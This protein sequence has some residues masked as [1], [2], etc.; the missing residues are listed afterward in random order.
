MEILCPELGL[1]A[2]TPTRAVT[3]TIYEDTAPSPVCPASEPPSP[4]CGPCPV[5]L[6][7][8]PKVPTSD[9]RSFPR[10]FTYIVSFNS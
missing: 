5:S 9:R 6:A 4:L 8:T 2:C 10:E 3:P 7:H 1:Q